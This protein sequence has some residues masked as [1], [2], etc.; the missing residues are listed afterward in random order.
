MEINLTPYK[1][2]FVTFKKASKKSMRLD[3]VL[4]AGK[5]NGKVFDI[6]KSSI[7]K[8]SQD[9][10]LASTPITDFISQG[11]SAIV[12]ETENGQVLKLTEGNHYPLG[13]S[14][15]NFDVPIYKQGK[16]KNIHYYFE[17]KL[18][19]HDMPDGF[20]EI[21]K[22][23]IKAKGYK[24]YDLE[25]GSTHQIGLSSSGKLYLVD[26]ECARH[27]TIFHAF[28]KKLKMSLPKN[29]CKLFRKI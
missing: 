15:E 27:K 13:R 16:I 4:L 1:T 20:V 19:Q 6:D 11:S 3:E 17:E 25:L 26:P 10:N 29:K 18:M 14:Q 28:W 8:I 24:P 7:K 9:K 5:I 2:N 23:M 22:D 21:M 12:F